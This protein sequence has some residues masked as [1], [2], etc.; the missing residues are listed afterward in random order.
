MSPAP[1]QSLDVP[2][3]TQPPGPAPPPQQGRCWFISGNRLAPSPQWHCGQLH[4]W[5]GQLHPGFCAEPGGQVSTGTS[6][7]QGPIRHPYP[8]PP[9]GAGQ[10]P[11]LPHKKGEAAP[12]VQKW[13]VMRNS[14]AL[15][16][17]QVQGDPPPRRQGEELPQ[18]WG[19]RPSGALGDR[20]V[21]LLGVA[22][23]RMRCWLR[24]AWAPSPPCRLQQRSRRPQGQS[25]T[26]TVASA[27][28]SLLPQGLCLRQHCLP[29]PAG[30]LPLPLHCAEEAA[31]GDVGRCMGLPCPWG[32]E[33]AS[34]RQDPRPGMGSSSSRGTEGPV[35]A[36]LEGPWL[37]LASISL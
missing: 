27:E 15:L 20:A 13:G 33:Q 24:Q 26:V 12:A 32:A 22:D 10:S 19:E 14:G 8:P 30:R 6:G 35:G 5:L 17:P 7:L 11:S 2:G 16:V 31:P 4:Q 23:L 34:S 29:H 18:P 37:G 1:W 9:T 21:R 25:R 3:L 36:P 28:L